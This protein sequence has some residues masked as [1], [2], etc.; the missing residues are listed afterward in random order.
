VNE[1]DIRN[2]CE[3]VSTVHEE[4]KESVEEV[5]GGDGVLNLVTR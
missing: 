3:M 2:A 1:A 4:M 5:K